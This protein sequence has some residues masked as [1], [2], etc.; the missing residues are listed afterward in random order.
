MSASDDYLAVSATSERVQPELDDAVLRSIAQSYYAGVASGALNPTRD[1][2]LADFFP[3]NYGLAQAYSPTQLQAIAARY[4]V[5][6]APPAPIG[7]APISATIS[8]DRVSDRVAQLAAL[9]INGGTTITTKAPTMSTAGGGFGGLP[10]GGPGL[11]ALP[12][13]TPNIWGAIGQ[14]LLNAGVT[15]A[16]NW[17]VNKI[18]QL[19]GTGG[20]QGGGGPPAVGTGGTVF[21]GQGGINLPM[22]GQQGAGGVVFQPGK[23]WVLRRTYNKV[24][25]IDRR[26]HIDK[27]GNF[28]L[29]APRMNV[30]NPHALHRAMRRV[31]GF[32]HVATEALKFMGY[33]VTGHAKPTKHK[34]RKR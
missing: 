8:E 31:S 22:G 20:D 33:H 18:G 27:M 32:H 34:R 19:T 10:T 13:G 29:N 28:V 12:A 11:P 21:G 3:A 6:D 17:A 23:G 4:A 2:S 30:L 5:G 24:Q 7:Y 16:G 14:Q 26:G 9:P 15:A 25:T 1:G